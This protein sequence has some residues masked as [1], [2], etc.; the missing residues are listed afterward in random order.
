[1]T[2]DNPFLRALLADP[3][4]DTLRLAMA[5]WFDENDQP[6]RAEFVR[7]QVELAHGAVDGARLRYLERR[8]RDLLIAH[9]TEW[10]A[11]LAKV[12]R[13]RPGQWGGWVFRR[14]FAEYFNVPAAVITK[15]GDKLARLTPI[16]E[17]FLRPVNA[18]AIMDLCV[19]PWFASVTHLYLHD[20]QITD[21]VATALL[22]SPHTGR[23]RV[24][25]F[26]ASELSPVTERVFW[27]RFPVP[28]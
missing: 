17:L 21:A 3:E 9:D 15:Y 6:A 1:M 22:D 25:Q 8:Q 28:S 4:D 14:G 5:D 19:R 7:V 18:T 2:P 23:L 24:L 10:V 13:C 12:L 16:R 26:R 27:S 20:L 11:P